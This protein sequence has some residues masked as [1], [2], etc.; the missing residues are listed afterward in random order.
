[1]NNKP[2]PLSEIVDAMDCQTDEMASYLY[3]ETGKIITIS[4]ETMRA[5]KENEP[6]EDRPQWQQKA[7]T[8]A[9]DFLRNEKE[10]IPLPTQFDI[11]EYEIM[12]RFCLSLEDR[13]IGVDLYY[14]IK[15]SGAFRRFKDKIHELGVADDWYKYREEALREQAKYW[16]MDNEV[17]YYEDSDS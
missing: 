7:I 8:E 16:C 12:E 3:K 13:E 11:H 6:L 1:M 9:H 2:V 14:A 4:D 15:G 5:A 10:Y 17:P